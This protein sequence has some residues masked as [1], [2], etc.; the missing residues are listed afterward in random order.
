MVNKRDAKDWAHEHLAAAPMWGYHFVPFTPAG[1][2]DEV[3]LRANVRR[4]LATPMDGMSLSPIAGE[5]FALTTAERRRIA[6]IALEEIG[7]AR[8]TCFPCTSDSSESTLEMVRFAQDAGIDLAF[9]WTPYEYAKRDDDVYDFFAY[10]DEHTDTAIMAYSSPHA[11]RLMSPE[12]VARIAELPSICS[13][14][15]VNPYE[16]F[17]RARELAGER[18]LVTYPYESRWLESIADGNRVLMSSPVLLFQSPDWTPVADY[19]RLAQEGRT[20]EARAI[21]DGLQPL[22]D[23]WNELF[24]V[25][26]QEGRHPA[27]GFKMWAHALGLLDSP[28]VRR[29]ERPV[30]PAVA[31]R[32]LAVPQLV[33]EVRR[34][35]E[36]VTSG[37]A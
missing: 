26:E 4:V 24:E 29:P 30:D 21:R 6:T 12:L 9:V 14:K 7:G 33:K 19:T 3:A 11:G 35:L 25:H 28:D 2:L 37:P 34:A 18:I 17:L 23:L 32:I 5:I 16:D 31:E 13:I 36:A 20:E 1:A 15:Y 10:I 22:R 27:A 8:L